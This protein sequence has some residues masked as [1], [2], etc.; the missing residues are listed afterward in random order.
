M[1]RGKVAAMPRLRSVRVDLS[2][3][4]L[5]EHEEEVGVLSEKLRQ[6]FEEK[7]GLEAVV[8]S[9]AADLK[10]MSAEMIKLIG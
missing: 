8:D 9:Q 7:A 1:S 6:L 4:G 2:D 3:N 5:R 10:L